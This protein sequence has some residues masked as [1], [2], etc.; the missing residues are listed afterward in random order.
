[1]TTNDGRTQQETTES[2]DSKPL[3]KGKA[4]SN[5][6]KQG[7]IKK[8][9]QNPQEET[10]GVTT[11]GSQQVTIGGRTSEPKLMD[12][13]KASALKSKEKEN[14][15]KPEEK[16]NNA[17]TMEPKLVTKGSSSGSSKAEPIDKAKASIV[18]SNQ[19]TIKNS[20]QKPEEKTNKLRIPGSK[21]ETAES[22]SSRPK[23]LDSNEDYPIYQDILDQVSPSQS[24]VTTKNPNSTQKSEDFPN[25]VD[26]NIT[27]T[28]EYSF[29]F[30]I[31]FKEQNMR[32]ILHSKRKDKI[33]Y[34]FQNMIHPTNFHLHGERLTCHQKVAAQ[35]R[36]VKLNIHVLSF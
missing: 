5:K 34:M 10:N 9:D 29:T 8:T 12:K 32:N 1:M 21:Q 6:A 36:K 35:R 4:S 22:S 20:S 2:S 23:P 24:P 14:I 19:G 31:G 15:L 13:P 33:F 27:E 11:V 16:T 26:V 7:K 18:K 25:Y 17:R 3:N 28:G 30:A